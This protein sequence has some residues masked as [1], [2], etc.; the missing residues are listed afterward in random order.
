VF[1]IAVR[2]GELPITWYGVLVAAGFFV[3]VRWTLGAARRDGLSGAHVEWLA[4]WVIVAAV[5]GSRAL[6]VL[7]QLPHFLAHPAEIFQPRRGGLVFLGGLLAAVAVG[8]LYMRLRRLPLLRYADLVAPG[9]ALG[10]AIGRLGCLAVGCCYGTPAAD[11][12]W[13]VRFPVSEWEQIAPAGVP[14]HPVQ[15]Y[16]FGA[17]LGIFALLLV[18]RPRRRFVGQIGLTYLALYGAARIVLEV[19]RGD[20][21]RGFVW[22][23]V[24]GEA[25][26]TSQFT[27]AMLLIA[28]VVG[29]ALLRRR[30]RAAS[31]STPP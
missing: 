10:H 5:V 17:N 26:S 14:L 16:E 20:G 3:G 13:A 18:L 4:F 30:A 21:E 15:L 8:A 28:A 19:F 9:I 11:L 31:G 1:P 12:P 2:L 23:G 24:L 22:Q 25:V 7:T 6:F 27:A 29:Y